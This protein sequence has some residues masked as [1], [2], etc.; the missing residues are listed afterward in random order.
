MGHWLI[1]Y[2]ISRTNISYS[3][4]IYTYS[5][6]LESSYSLYDRAF[7]DNIGTVL[8][9]AV[10]VSLCSFIFVS[11]RLR[12]RKGFKVDRKTNQS[13]RF[14]ASFLPHLNTK[15]IYSL[16]VI[17]SSSSF[18]VAH[19]VYYYVCGLRET[20]NNGISS[21]K[22]EQGTLVHGPLVPSSK[23]RWKRA[24]QLH[25]SWHR[26][27]WR[28]VDGSICFQLD[29]LSFFLS[30]FGGRNVQKASAILKDFAA[31]DICSC[32]HVSHMTRWRSAY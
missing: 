8:F 1:S 15:Y 12:G 5:I 24:S 22:N 3:Y 19:S 17:T 16:P 30:T 28:I 21:G 29:L 25:N 27:R 2:L 7:A 32:D 18:H 13:T 20:R 31:T 11:S 6:I 4:F 9:Y 10:I 26:E 23:H 14:L